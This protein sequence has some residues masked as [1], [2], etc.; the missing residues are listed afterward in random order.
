MYAGPRW[1]GAPPGLA[2]NKSLDL[3]PKPAQLNIIYIMG[4]SFISVFALFS[5]P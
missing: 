4:S 5:T 1:P 3:A 2:L